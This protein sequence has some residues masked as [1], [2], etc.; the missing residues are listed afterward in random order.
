[1]VTPLVLSVKLLPAVRA[2]SFQS[3]MALLGVISSRKLLEGAASAPLRMTMPLSTLALP[4]RKPS[5]PIA[6]RYST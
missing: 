5:K 4:A 6:W 1:M 3:E 2:G